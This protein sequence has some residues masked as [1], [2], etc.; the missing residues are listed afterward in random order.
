[1]SSRNLTSVTDLGLLF[2]PSLSGDAIHNCK[3][4][5]KLIGKHYCKHDLVLATIWFSKAS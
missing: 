5:C 4:S 2:T 1:M 3:Q